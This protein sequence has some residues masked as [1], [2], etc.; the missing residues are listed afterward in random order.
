MFIGKIGIPKVNFLL[1]FMFFLLQIEINKKTVY[2][3]RWVKNIYVM[4]HEHDRIIVYY[5]YFYS[6]QE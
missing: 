4:V 5:Y 3:L 1:Y 6:V 2:N